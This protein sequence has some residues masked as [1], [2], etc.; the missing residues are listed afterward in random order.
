MFIITAFVA[1]PI[2]PLTR[3]TARE[4]F[5][6]DLAQNLPQKGTRGNQHYQDILPCRMQAV[7][8]EQSRCQLDLGV[9]EHTSPTHDAS[10][11]S[12]TY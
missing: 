5:P 4:T 12:K 3:G 1:P 8:G 11:D 6:R 9:E 10:G 2:T 7:D